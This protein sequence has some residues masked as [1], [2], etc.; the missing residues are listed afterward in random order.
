MGQQWPIWEEKE[1]EQAERP[2]QVCRLITLYQSSSVSLQH[3]YATLTTACEKETESAQALQVQSPPKSGVHGVSLS[4]TFS[5]PALYALTISHEDNKSLTTVLT[6]RAFFPLTQHGNTDL[7]QETRC[8]FFSLFRHVISYQLAS[9]DGIFKT[10]DGFGFG[11]RISS[12]CRLY[13][14]VASEV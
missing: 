10:K 12:R 2:R 11:G 14:N 13:S 3:F 1:A 9:S 8:T 7:A 6:V 5:L 4:P